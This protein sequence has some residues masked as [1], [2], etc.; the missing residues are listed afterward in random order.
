MPATTAKGSNSSSH[1]HNQTCSRAFDRQ[2]RSRNYRDEQTTNDGSNQAH[3]GWEIR[4]F[5]NPQT[6]GHSQ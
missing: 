5:G 4:S 1:H 3:D 2:A 6:E